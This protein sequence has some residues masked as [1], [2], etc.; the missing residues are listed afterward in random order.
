MKRIYNKNLKNFSRKLRKNS[1]PAEILLWREVLKGRKMRGYQFNRQFI[2]G[3]YIVD[4]I[5]RKL[6]L[7]IEIDGYSHNL[8]FERHK[9]KDRDL[10]KM[11]YIVLH[12]SEKDVL[13]DIESVKNTLSVILRKLKEEMR[14]KHPPYPPSKEGGISNILPLGEGG[15]RGIVFLILPLGEGGLR[16]IVPSILPL[17]EGGQR[18]IVFLPLEQGNIGYAKNELF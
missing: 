2:I 4:F 3:N 6:R 12:I 11:G 16:G 1:T 5:C 7:I 8:K 15:K 14:L 10:R 17:G 13:R 18:R 9:K